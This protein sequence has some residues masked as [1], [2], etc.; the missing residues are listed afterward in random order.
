MGASIDT[1]TLAPGQVFFALRG[2][3]TDGHAHVGAAGAAGASIAVV[4]DA[5]RA[6]DRPEELA[7]MLVGD[8][9]E[10]LGR[11]ARA[12]REAAPNLRVVGVTGSNGKTT[13]VRLIDAVL[14][15]SLRG[16]AS[17]KSFNNDLGLPLTLLGARPGDQYVVCEMGTSGPGEIGRIAGMARPD[18]AVITMVG[19]AHVER[20]GSLEGVAAEK[21]S[22]LLHVREGGVGV[23]PAGCAVLERAMARMELPRLVR[24]GEDEAADLRVSGVR[25]STR[26]VSFEVNGRAR[27]SVGLMG[28]HNAHNGAMAVA[29][30]R[31]FGLDDEAIAR[32][33]ASAV[34]AEG[35]LA[36]A[37]IR[38]PE[39]PVRVVNDA[40]NANPDSMAA[41]LVTLASLKPG[42]GG[43]RVAILGDMLELGEASA[44]AHEEVAGRVRSSRSIHAAVLVGEAMSAAAGS[45]GAKAVAVGG[46]EGGE[47]E[48]IAGMVRGGDVVLLKASRG[49]RLERVA[50][51]IERRFGAA[52]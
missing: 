39:G 29:V 21:A 7:L 19:R 44:G 8:A 4:D 46:L 48:R 3:R 51:A 37:T 50:E 16:S 20:L 25:C 33:L 13:T 45:A 40:Y 47:A 41:A 30:G 28:A 9:R 49:M 43:R 24:V 18:V 36:A 42:P 34:G 32:G 11:M 26:G 5:A 15:G 6:A 1:R 52:R 23:V 35:R 38:T 17:V 10:A 14:R 12:W 22:I 27:F 2:E 31:R